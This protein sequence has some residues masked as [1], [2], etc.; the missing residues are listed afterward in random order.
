MAESKEEIKSPLMKLKEGSEKVVL[1]SA[2]KKLKL[3][4]QVPSLHG[5]LPDRWGNNGN[6]E[7]LY[8]GAPKLL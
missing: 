4:H 8:L 2:F 6:S 3:W 7:R 1:N 5:K